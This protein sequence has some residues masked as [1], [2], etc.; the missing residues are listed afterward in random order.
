VKRA[1]IGIALLLLACSP[2]GREPEAALDQRIAAAPGGLLQVDLDLGS[3]ARPDRVSLEVRAHDA[4]EVWAVADVSGPGASSVAFRI[5]H[6]GARVRLYARS[7]GVWSWLFGGPSVALRV[8]VPREFSLD[9]RSAS[10]PIRIED[11]SGAIRARTTDGR[12]EVRAADGPLRVHSATGTVSLR[13]ISGDVEVR[14]QDAA[15]EL[16]WIRGRVDARTG[17]GDIAANHLE[18]AIELSSDRGEIQLRDV[19]GPVTARTELGP[20]FASFLAD[21]SGSLET[22]RGSLEVTLPARSHI[23]LEASAKRGA[24]ELGPGLGFE[25]ERAQDHLSGRLNGGGETL[26]L[27]SAHGSV[28]VDPR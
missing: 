23:V 15:I 16:D 6:D 28:R 14:A 2:D 1:G 7:R 26:R 24:V 19:R 10:G 11:V 8:F 17:A 13:E 9:L 21:A 4:D 3:E 20:I 5:E 18:G 27:Y 12:L 22:Q 25:G